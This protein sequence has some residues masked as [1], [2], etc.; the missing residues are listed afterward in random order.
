MP[1]AHLCQQAVHFV[2]EVYSRSL[3]IRRRPSLDGLPDVEKVRSFRRD[4]GPMPQL[5]PRAARPALLAIP[6]D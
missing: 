3:P 4:E 1:P 5:A 2:L 6:L